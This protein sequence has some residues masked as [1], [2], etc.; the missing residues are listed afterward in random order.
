MIRTVL[1][2]GRSDYETDADL[3]AERDDAAALGLAWR[4]APGNAKPD[5]EQVGALVVPS[6][7]RLAR[8]DLQRFGGNLIV[9]TT[10]GY[11]HI[12]LVAAR[13]LGITVA[14]CPVARRDP[15]AHWCIAAME[16]LL[17]KQPA[18]QAAALEGRWIRDR[19]PH[20][21][22]RSLAGATVAVVGVGVI[23]RKT[24]TLLQAFGAQVIGV[25][26]KGVPSDLEARTIDDALPDCDA[27]TL[28][29][30]LDDATAGLLS[31]DRLR[32]L[33]SHAVVV[34][35][36]RGHVLAL[37]AAMRLLHDGRLGGLAVDVYPR[38]PWRLLAETASLPGVWATPHAAGFVHDLGQ[39]VRS[40]VA[41]A[42][43]AWVI[44]RPIPH[45]I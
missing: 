29:C 23:G 24:A 9:A 32:A 35:T 27:V 20:M 45:V 12:D 33:P 10:S 41:A 13:E 25:D 3:A 38:E 16:A 36:S 31:D 34:N 2:W 42:L 18:H 37:D 26:P 7:T 44:G 21:A 19:L 15:V 43:S 5:L 39:R 8:P 30:H 6:G 4:S 17:R 11:D 14:R 22:P 40:E 28:H 1:R